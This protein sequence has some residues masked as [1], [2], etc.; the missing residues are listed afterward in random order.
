MRQGAFVVAVLLAVPLVPAP[1][2]G[3]PPPG[4]GAVGA[5]VRRLQGTW[6]LTALELNGEK[7]EPGEGITLVISG[8]RLTIAEGVRFRLT[9]D[10]TADPKVLDLTR[11]TEDDKGPVL[12]GIYALRGETLTLCLYGGEGPKSRPTEF[13][14]KPGSGRVLAVLQRQKD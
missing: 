2:V 14:A 1:A 13:E 8:D 9:V 7:Q 11:L 3:L 5:E 10:P 12:E 4:G 6:K